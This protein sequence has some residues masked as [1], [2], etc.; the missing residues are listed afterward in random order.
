MSWT[1]WFI[2]KMTELGKKVL[3]KIDDTGESLVNINDNDNTTF[4]NEKNIQKL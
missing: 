1:P 2:C 3:N 4:P